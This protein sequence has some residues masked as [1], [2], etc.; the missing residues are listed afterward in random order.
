[1]LKPRHGDIPRGAH[2]A[3]A[4]P[5]RRAADVA[6]RLRSLEREKR[7]A[8]ALVQVAE[9]AGAGLALTDVLGRFCRLTVELVPCDRCT[10]YLWGSR[11]QTYIPVAACGTP[12][13]VVSRFVDKY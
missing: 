6:E 1:M 13:H 5:R 4:A 7:V 9:Q 11:R 10:L 12:P 3:Q 8:D 2:G